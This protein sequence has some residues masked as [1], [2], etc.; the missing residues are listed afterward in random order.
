MRP[1]SKLGARPSPVPPIPPLPPMNRFRPARPQPGNRLRHDIGTL[2]VDKARPTER[3]FQQPDVI[4]SQAGVDQAQ[5]GDDLIQRSPPE[6][7]PEYAVPRPARG[8]RGPHVVRV[9]E[10]IVSRARNQPAVS[11]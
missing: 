9:I 2:Q 11:P 6:L 8:K 7:R 10:A 1:A 4:P 3:P 5:L